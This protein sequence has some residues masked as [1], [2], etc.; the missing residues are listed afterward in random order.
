MLTKT[1]DDFNSQT[2]YSRIWYNQLN[3]A[4]PEPGQGGSWVLYVYAFNDCMQK[5]PGRDIDADESPWFETSC[6]TGSSGQ[7]QSVP[8]TIRSFGIGPGEEYN[9]AKEECNPWAYQGYSGAQ[10][11]FGNQIKGLFA[12][13]AGLTIILLII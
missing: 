9:E 1:K 10:A 7:C 12:G 3:E 5:K 8:N 2:N 4:I 6:Q 11:V 13:V